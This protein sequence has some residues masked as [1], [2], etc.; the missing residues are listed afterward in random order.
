MRQMTDP[1]TAGDVFTI[2][3]PLFLALHRTGV[4]PLSELSMQYEDVLAKRL[5]ENREEAEAVDLLQ[6]LVA[7]LHRLAQ[8][9]GPGKIALPGS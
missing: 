3:S 7:G 5:L 6:Q 4:L 1:C 9:E 8:A 2:L